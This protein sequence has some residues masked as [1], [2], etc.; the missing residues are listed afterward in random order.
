MV[1]GPNF[2]QLKEMLTICDPDPNGDIHI[3]KQ[4]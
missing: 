3:S 4:G 2:V 1:D